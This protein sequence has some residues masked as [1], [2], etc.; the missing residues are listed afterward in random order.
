MN[1][2]KDIQS[3]SD[4]KQNASRIVKEVRETKEPVIVTVNG[5]AAVVIQDAESY[6]RMVDRQEYDQTVRAL[7]AV[8]ADIDDPEKWMSAEEAFDHLRSKY[9]LEKPVA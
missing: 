9:N 1:I 5:R 3:L 6:Q 8:I 2:M 7:R 4:F